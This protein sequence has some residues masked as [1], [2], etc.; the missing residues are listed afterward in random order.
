M[1]VNRNSLERT[2]EAFNALFV[3][4]LDAN[5]NQGRQFVERLGRIVPSNAA[6]ETYMWLLRTGG[7]RKWEGERV[8]NHFETWELSIEADEWE[9]S[10]EVDFK[11]LENDRIGLYAPQ[12][13]GMAEDVFWHYAVLFT[14][15]LKSG[16]S[17]EIYNGENF[18]DTAHPNPGTN[19]GSTFSNK[20]TRKLGQQAFK[21]IEDLPNDQL[22]RN[23]RRRGVSYDTL[24][25]T[26]HNIRLAERLNDDEF[27]LADPTDPQ[28]TYI[29]NEVR[30]TFDQIVELEYAEPAMDEML[31]ATD[32]RLVER[33]P[34]LLLQQVRT[35]QEN[36]V[37]SPSMD[38]KYVW[39]QR[40]MPMG[41]DCEHG[42]GYGLPHA[43]AASDGTT[44]A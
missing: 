16:F 29:K 9:D 40:K 35:P 8:L 37:T 42:A 15:L 32:S 13:A 23:G 43:I 12:I 19:G 22:D 7:L 5:E 17:T 26:S 34:P 18:F 39:D 33:I 11:D 41:I 21:D 10:I 36:G 1:N 31:F 4:T 3:S 14:D 24:F 38:S 25:V 28:S 27:V 44:P 6:K 30:G 2:R 20:I